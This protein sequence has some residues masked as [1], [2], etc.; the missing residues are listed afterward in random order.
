MNKLLTIGIPTYNRKDQ[1]FKQVNLFCEFITKNSLNEFV[2]LLVI[3]N[4]SDFDIFKLLEEPLEK[5]KDFLKITKNQENIG[6]TKNIIET[7]VQSQGSYYYFIGD[8]DK[9]NL[10]SLLKG[11]NLIRQHLDLPEVIIFGVKNLLGYKQTFKNVKKDTYQVVKNIYLRLPIY[12]MGNACMFVSTKDSEVLLKKENQTLFETT[13]IPH[14]ALAIYLLKKKDYVALY[15]IEILSESFEEANNIPTS[16]SVLNTRFY[17]SFLVDTYLKLPKNNFLKRH[18][19]MQLKNII[20]YL[21]TI[22]LFYHFKDSEKQRQQYKQFLKHNLLSK[23]MNFIFNIVTNDFLK[24]LSYV[25]ISTKFLIK[26]Q[27]MFTMKGL[28]Q[29]YKNKN[30]KF[31]KDKNKHHWT[32]DFKF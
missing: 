30:E 29:F 3:D 2:E 11:I 1:I 19:I 12:Y 21:L 16:W 7:I 18:P 14:T 9:P 22:S 31:L 4:N 32:A 27:K 26:E 28:R 5:F 8:D 15:N 20:L 13:P 24:I 25:A 6:M 17:Y 23:K 10:D